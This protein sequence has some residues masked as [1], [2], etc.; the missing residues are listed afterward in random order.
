MQAKE[1]L[2]ILAF[3]FR[4]H[5]AVEFMVVAIDHHSVETS[6]L[7]YRLR[8]DR[9]EAL[10]VG[11]LIEGGNGAPHSEIRIGKRERAGALSG[12]S[13][14]KRLHESPVE[15]DVK[16]DHHSVH[17]NHGIERVALPQVAE[18]PDG[19]LDRRRDVR[20]EHGYKFVADGVG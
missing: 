7:P 2:E 8:R 19:S 20:A 6:E 9:V 12:S 16:L 14:I 5:F 17:L 4:H 13:S 11:C 15:N 18:C 3:L 1:G 10:Q